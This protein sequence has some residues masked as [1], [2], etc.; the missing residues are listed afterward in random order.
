MADPDRSAAELVALFGEIERAPHQFDFF[1]A[2]R[3]VECA[4]ADHPRLGESARRKTTRSA[5]ARNRRWL[6]HRGR[7]VR[8]LPTAEGLPPRMEVFFFGLFGPNGPLPLHLTEYARNRLRQYGDPTF[9][10]FADIFHHRLLSLF[11][12]AWANAQ[13]TVNLDRPESDRFATY[14][15]CADRPGQSGHA[16]RDSLPDR[17]KLHFAGRLS[18]GARHPEGLRAM[19]ASS[20]VCR[21][22]SK[23]S[24]AAGR[25]SRRALAANWAAGTNYPMVGGAAVLGVSS[26]IGQYVWDCQQTFRIVMGPVSL[27]DYR[28][29][30][31]GGKG[32][33]NSKTW[34]GTTSATS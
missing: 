12:R 5:W 11:Y 29:L 18:S 25:R 24:S 13:P 4:A 7:S 32:L 10:R 20:S 16:A 9:A 33:P 14:V 17:F 1:Q 30:L 15:G 27:D 8:W 22:P 21:W 6:S 3:R 26:T 28:R 2:L 19:I 34:C 31:P 23:S